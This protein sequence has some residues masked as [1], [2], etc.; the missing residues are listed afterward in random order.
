MQPSGIKTAWQRT[1]ILH[2]AGRFPFTPEH[3]ILPCLQLTVTGNA[4]S[5][6]LHEFSAVPTF[7]PRFVAATR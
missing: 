7:V 6:R 4:I 1:Q 5:D 3:Q 2:F